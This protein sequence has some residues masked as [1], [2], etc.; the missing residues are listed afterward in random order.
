LR[1]EVVEFR[2][3]VDGLEGTVGKSGEATCSEVLTLRHED[4]TTVM[5]K[6]IRFSEGQRDEEEKDASITMGN[7]IDIL[8]EIRISRA[9]GSRR[10]P[11]FPRVSSH[12]ER[13]LLN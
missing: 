11:R 5:L 6:I 10:I 7:L 1:N 3:Y 13:S 4:G 9:M 2:E 12:I 8:Q